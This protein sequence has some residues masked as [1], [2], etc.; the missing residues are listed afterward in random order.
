MQIENENFPSWL[1]VA[2]GYGGDSMTQPYPDNEKKEYRQYYLSVD[3][4]LNKIKTK[5]KTVNTVLHTFGFLKFPAPTLE[6]SKGNISFH[7]IYY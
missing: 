4:D 3:V 7:P 1:S 2:L 5:N 6:F